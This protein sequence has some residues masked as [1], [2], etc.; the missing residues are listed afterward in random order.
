MKKKLINIMLQYYYNIKIM[1]IVYSLDQYVFF[2]MEYLASKIN[3]Q[4]LGLLMQYRYMYCIFYLYLHLY[5]LT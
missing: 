4:A 3:I 2:I 5:T 1:L